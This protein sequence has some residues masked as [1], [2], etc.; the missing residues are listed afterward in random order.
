MREW[1]SNFTRTHHRITRWSRI[2]R[3][4]RRRRRCWWGGAT[5]PVRSSITLSWR[6]CTRHPPC[7]AYSAVAC[8]MRRRRAGRV[9]QRGAARQARLD[10]LHAEL[11]ALRTIE[12]P[13]GTA[14]ATVLAKAAA[15]PDAA[16]A[17]KAAAVQTARPPPMAVRLG[18]APV[19]LPRQSRRI[20]VLVCRESG[21]A[22][23]G[24]VAKRRPGQILGT[25][26]QP[27]CHRL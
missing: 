11:A 1:P 14:L 26:A 20:L 16:T 24:S 10:S 22:W 3:R 13:D 19:S 18:L 5:S 9:W 21:M 4:R 8:R 6:S 15:E 7:T 23:L 12:D 27:E 2:C 17:I 25:P